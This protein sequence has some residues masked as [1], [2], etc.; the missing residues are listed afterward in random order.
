MSDRHNYRILEIDFTT[1]NSD[2]DIA[3]VDGLTFYRDHQSR[4][5]GNGFSIL[6]YELS[7]LE[8]GTKQSVGGSDLGSVEVWIWM[9][10]QLPSP[11]V[12]VMDQATQS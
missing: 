4:K 9:P 12:I 3:E 11:S 7:D 2:D 6:G 8:G 5:A 10:Q 1:D